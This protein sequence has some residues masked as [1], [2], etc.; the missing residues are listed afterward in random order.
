MAAPLETGTNN[1]KRREKMKPQTKN[2][3]RWT[4]LF[5]TICIVWLLVMFLCIWIEGFFYSPEL[6]MS[7]GNMFMLLDLLI[8]PSIAIFF[9]AR[10]I[11]PKYKNIVGIGSVVLCALWCCYFILTLAQSY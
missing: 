9:T 1:I 7:F 6:W 8:I 11:A 5:P 4:I 10:Y 2:I 3:I